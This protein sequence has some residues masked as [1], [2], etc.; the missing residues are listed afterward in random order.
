VSHYFGQEML[1]ARHDFSLID[2]KLLPY[3]LLRSAVVRLHR[4]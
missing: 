3:L 4:R 2:V 1:G